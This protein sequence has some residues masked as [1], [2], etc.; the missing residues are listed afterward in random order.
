MSKSI[1]FFGAGHADGDGKQKEL[2]GGKGAGLAEMTRL[3]IPVPPGFTITTTV[4]NDFFAAGGK[5][6]DALKDEVRA[7]LD[8][9]AS[10][11]GTRFGDPSAPLLFSVRSGAR[12]SMPG[13]MDTILNL[14]LNDA[15]AKG[16]AERTGNRKFALDAQR[17]FILLYSSVVLEIPRDRFEHALS[18]ARAK[19]A[20]HLGLDPTRFTPAELER[21][22]PD[23][24][25]DEEA[26]SDLIA[27]EKAIVEKETG[28]PFPE[29][30]Y[31]QLW[32]A[33]G[34]VFKS[35]YNPRA[36]V[37][38]GMHDIPESWGTACNVQ[39][40]VFGN[41][42][43]DSGTGV[44]FTRDPSTGER[45]FYG[46][47]LPNAQGEDVV[48]GVRTPLPVSKGG[49][50]DANSLEVKMPDAYTKLVDIYQRLE[51][52]FRDMQDI[53]FTVQ[54]GTLYMLQCRTGKRTGKAAVRIAVEMAKE[55]LI[56]EREA[57]LRV[58]PSSID[59][60]LHPSIDPHAEKKFLARGLP[61]SPGAASG[62]VVFHADE[63]ERLA[64]RGKPVILVRAET[65]PEDIHGMKA[66][67]GILTARGGMTS[68]AAVVAR[69]MGKSCVA[70]CS[71]IAIRYES[72]EMHITVYDS[73]GRPAETV[74]V[75]GETSSPSTAAQAAST[76]APSP[77]S[78]RPSPASSASS[79]SGPTR[80]ASS[81]SAPTPTPR[82]TRAPPATSARRE[83]A[84]AAP[85]TCSSTTS[86]SPPSAR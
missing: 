40:M 45:R 23:S 46:E 78:P 51:T 15:I 34:A 27:S 68:H 29:D 12:A 66:A 48:A 58:D 59:Q 53:E 74:V 61:A 49:G 44:A 14:G 13:M 47:W 67:R 69:G 18:A 24:K 1:Y 84:S 35:W 25:L 33:I 30:P 52:H 20:R 6:P 77:P 26:L 19:A 21:K 39:A 81:E 64:G 16:L 73:D 55:G 63:A 50:D 80:S 79:W 7:S 60:L 4:C 32:G 3:G 86:A 85:S 54:S 38:R 83:S 75:K 36:K 70:G 28:K 2:L 62:H 42:G 41:L 5:L 31:E 57:I 43:D 22:V 76:S 10:I 11:V 17:R 65:S 71:S 56:T 72:A 9:V 82:S 37:Y 8:R